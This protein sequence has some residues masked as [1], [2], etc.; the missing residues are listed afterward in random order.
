MGIGIAPHPAI[1]KIQRRRFIL[2]M[3]AE[4]MSAKSKEQKPA[5]TVI[6]L[7][8]E[9]DLGALGKIPLRL[10]FSAHGGHLEICE[11]HRITPGGDVPFP[12]LDLIA[13]ALGLW[14]DPMLRGQQSVA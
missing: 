11:V 14:L 5:G 9:I 2:P 8:R 13:D 10:T 6:R 3:K 12:Q 1:A 7:K 4:A